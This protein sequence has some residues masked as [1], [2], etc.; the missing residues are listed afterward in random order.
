MKA[1]IHSLYLTLLTVVTLMSMG[2]EALYKAWNAET[3]QMFHY[4]AWLFSSIWWLWLIALLLGNVVVPG[5][6]DLFDSLSLKFSRKPGF[7]VA[8]ALAR[9][10]EIGKDFRQSCRKLH[11]VPPDKAEPSVP[12]SEG[13][14]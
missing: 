11:D 14:C 4:G 13:D 5:L 6:L 12:R 8:A 7:D 9:H 2:G 3:A 10:A 1:L